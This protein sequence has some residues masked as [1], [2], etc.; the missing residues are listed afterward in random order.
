[1]F[2]SPYTTLICQR[3]HLFIFYSSLGITFG[4]HGGGEGRILMH[5]P[6]DSCFIKSTIKT[7]NSGQHCPRDS[8]MMQWAFISG[9]LRKY[10][11]PWEVKWTITDYSL[12]TKTAVRG[13][14]TNT[15]EE[16]SKKT[17]HAVD[18]IQ[19]SCRE[20]IAGV[21]PIKDLTFQNIPN[22]QLR[23][24]SMV[25]GWCLWFIWTHHH[26]LRRV[27]SSNKHT[28]RTHVQAGNDCVGVLDSLIW[29]DHW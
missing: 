15:V 7:E 2:Y 25:S 28:R 23:M 8:Y 16:T 12:L 6:V 5:R 14:W 21:I 3:L 9:A 20:L 11:P 26:T 4:P 1:M 17:Q 27:S 10:S 13:V 24:N 19:D 29:T 18:Y 22:D